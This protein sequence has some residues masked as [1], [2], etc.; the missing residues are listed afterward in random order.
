M[1][2]AEELQR[3][4]FAALKADAALQ[5]LVDGIFDRVPDGGGFGRHEAYVSFGPHDVVEDDADCILGDAHT[6]QLDVWS[7]AVGATAA[8]AICGRVKL[9]L[10]EQDLPFTVNALV[11]L[12][13]AST[14]TL[15]DPDGLTTHGI[16]VLAAEIETAA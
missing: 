10:H 3:A 15:A 9:L 7:R 6:L 12:R 1:S 13:V 4:V 5:G 16:V 14:R 2:P 11:E 8:K